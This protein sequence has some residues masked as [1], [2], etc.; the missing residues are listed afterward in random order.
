MIEI[1][2]E[3]DAFFSADKAIRDLREAGWFESGLHVLV[4]RICREV[5]R[6]SVKD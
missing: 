5:P 2:I 6:G 1:D 4:G 3:Q